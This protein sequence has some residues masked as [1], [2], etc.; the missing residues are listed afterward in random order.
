MLA[1][2]SATPA[3][4]PIQLTVQNSPAPPLPVENPQ[5]PEQQKVM[6]DYEQWLVHEQE[7]GVSKPCWGWNSDWFYSSW[8]YH[9]W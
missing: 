8:A 3:A 5:T 7:V 6:H 4:P 2:P 9:W 1:G